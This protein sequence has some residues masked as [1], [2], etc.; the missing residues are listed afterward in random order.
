MEFSNKERSRIELSYIQTLQN[1]KKEC[2]SIIIDATIFSDV[3]LFLDKVFSIFIHF[4]NIGDNY[5]GGLNVEWHHSKSFCCTFY[6]NHVTVDMF[7][8]QSHSIHDENDQENLFLNFKK[9]MKNIE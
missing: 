7:D 8:E 9:F 3:L 4:P 1:H 5:D 6:K 2:D